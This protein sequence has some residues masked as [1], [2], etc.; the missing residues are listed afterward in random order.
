MRDTLNALVS[1]MQATGHYAAV[2][3]GDPLKNAPQS[4]TLQI[5]AL[6]QT[7]LDLNLD[8]PQEQHTFM[9]RYHVRAFEDEEA[10]E[11]D[12]LFTTA[13]T[14]EVLLSDFDLSSYGGAETGVLEVV[15]SEMET[16]FGT[17]AIDQS[18][19]RV[20]DMSVP[21][22]VDGAVTFAR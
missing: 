4:R 19:Y 20:F 2:V 14:R 22:W 12:V 13:R 21:V 11:E 7:F 15:P 10:A 1:A 5:F 16:N 17:V 6:S 3:K 9:L 18:V 8:T